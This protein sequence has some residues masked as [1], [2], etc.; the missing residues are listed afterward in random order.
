MGSNRIIY[1]DWIVELGHDPTQAYRLTPGPEETYNRAIITAVN[2]AMEALDEEERAFIR[3]YYLQGMSYRQISRI[4]GQ[5]IY[6]LENLHQNAVR[7]LKRRLSGLLGGR[8]N[9][10]TEREIVCPLCRHPDV[11]KINALILSKTREETWKRII[12][13]LRDDFAVA[14]VMP[15]R[16]IGH[17]KYHMI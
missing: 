8:F 14:G 7:R 2:R 10:S 17:R 4:T 11:D 5:A 15:Q 6:R 9:I 16:L 12:R 1:Q 3:A 13:I